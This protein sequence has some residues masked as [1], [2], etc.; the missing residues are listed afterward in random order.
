M[1]QVFLKSAQNGARYIGLWPCAVD[2]GQGK[3]CCGES[4][5]MCKGPRAVRSPA[6]SKKQGWCGQSSFSGTALV[7]C[8]VGKTVWARETAQGPGEAE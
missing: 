3:A 5:H 7:K 6:Y 8:A 4:A 1:R 2:V